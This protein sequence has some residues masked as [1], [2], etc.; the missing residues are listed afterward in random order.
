MACNN[1]V[2]CLAIETRSTRPFYDKICIE[3]LHR[4]IVA[5][6]DTGLLESAKWGLF[7]P[8]DKTGR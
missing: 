5:I 6:L 3:A 4:D 8:V 1:Y 2:Y 7:Y